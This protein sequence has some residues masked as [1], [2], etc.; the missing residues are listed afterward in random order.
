[1]LYM[2]YVLGAC[3]LSWVPNI[4]PDYPLFNFIFKLYFPF[5]CVRP[6]VHSAHSDQIDASGAGHSAILS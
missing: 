1:M 2:Y 3:M 4:N 6:S 5:F